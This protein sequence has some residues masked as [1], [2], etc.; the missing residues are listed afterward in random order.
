MEARFRQSSPR[1]VVNGP[2]IERFLENAGST[3]LEGLEQRRNPG[4][5]KSASRRVS[6]LRDALQT[7]AIWGTGMKRT[8]SHLP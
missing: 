6:A 3:V 1:I 7:G 8:L 2:E 5:R 4:F